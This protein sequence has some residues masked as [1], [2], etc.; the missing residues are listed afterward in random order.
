MPPG[1]RLRGG[2]SVQVLQNFFRVPFRLHVIENVCDFSFRIDDES[3]ARDSFHLFPIH[4]L[5]FDYAESFADFLVGVGQQLVGQAV[6]ILK[7]FLGLRRVG[8][9][10]EDN[11]AGFLQ[12]FVRVAEPARFNGSAG[13]VGLRKKEKNHSLAAKIFQG[14]ILSALVRQS[15]VAGF[16]IDIHGSISSQ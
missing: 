10:P 4:V 9:D 16:I 5:F 11:G 14:N 13:G 12:L 1:C 7:L 2:L 3:R 8:R 6:L 15:E